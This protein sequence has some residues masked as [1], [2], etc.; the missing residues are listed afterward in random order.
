MFSPWRSVGLLNGKMAAEKKRRIPVQTINNRV[1]LPLAGETSIAPLISLVGAQTST[2]A[3]KAWPM[4]T[5]ATQKLAVLLVVHALPPLEHSGTPAIAHT[6]ARQLT[7]QGLRVGVLSGAIGH[8]APPPLQAAT[9]EQHGFQRF[10]VPCTRH[11]WQHWSI[12]E[13]SV[14]ASPEQAAALHTVLETFR[15]DLVHILDL[16]NLPGS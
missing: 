9:D 5:D 10:E 13:A 11:L 16:V 8:T 1:Y 6:Y 12:H 14:P 3:Q 15:P 7:A 4:Q 2:A